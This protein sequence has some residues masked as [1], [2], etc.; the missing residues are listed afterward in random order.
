MS[1]GHVKTSFGLVGVSAGLVR[2][3]AGHVKVSVGLVRVSAG[4]VY[5]VSW[6]V[7]YL[8]GLVWVS[9]SLVR[10]SAGHDGAVVI[11]E[12]TVALHKRQGDT[13]VALCLKH[14][15]LRPVL[16]PFPG[17]RAPPFR[18]PTLDSFPGVLKSATAARFNSCRGRWQVPVWR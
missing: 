13:G 2:V 10:V 7:R 15:Y 6:S 9:P 16:W 14:P 3:S 8:A 12:I 11:M 17:H 18:S 1:A 4:L 5:G